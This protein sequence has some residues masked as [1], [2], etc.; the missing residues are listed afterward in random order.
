MVISNMRR[1]VA[2]NKRD[3]PRESHTPFKELWVSGN[4]ATFA[5]RREKSW[6]NKLVKNIPA[7]EHDHEVRGIVLEFNL[8]SFAPNGQPRDIDNL[9]EPVF[10]V[11]VNRIGW[12]GGRRPNIMWWRAIKNEK[13]PFGCRF[14]LYEDNIQREKHNDLIFQGYYRGT[15]PKKATDT[16]IPNWI[17]KNRPLQFTETSNYSVYLLFHNSRVN[18]GDIATG[19]IKST[20][21]C[22]Y[23]ILGG[24]SGRP[25]DWRIQSLQVEKKEQKGRG[26]TITVYKIE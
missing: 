12:F 24:T 19:P 7:P 3:S 17:Y 11:L 6:K 13:R 15:L 9:C 22:L 26:V 2:G 23:P 1:I 8:K 18:L 4:P 14:K 10:S 21:D 16:K 20:I 5:T 25:D